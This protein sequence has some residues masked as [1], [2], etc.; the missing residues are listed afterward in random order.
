MIRNITTNTIISEEER[1]CKT[2]FS[3]AR[4][5]MFRNKQNLVME[6]PEERKISL[7]M[8]FVFYPIDV[9]VLDKNKKVVERKRNFWPFTVWN[10]VKKGKYVIE[11]GI[12]NKKLKINVG[13]KI[14]F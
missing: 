13:D 7:H 1:Y 9:F 6:F 10:S 5:L 2:I 4:G 14:L 8:F 12:I 11:L 3:Q